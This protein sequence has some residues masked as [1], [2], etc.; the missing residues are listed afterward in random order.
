MRERSPILCN[1]PARRRRAAA[2]AGAFRRG[3]TLSDL[4]RKKGLQP[5]VDE[6]KNF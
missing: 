5:L 4:Y 6:L 2:R 3:T 1:G